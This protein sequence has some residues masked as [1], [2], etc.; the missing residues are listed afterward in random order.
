MACRQNISRRD[1]EIES[2]DWKR[3]RERER[4]RERDRERET[5]T[6]RERDRQTDRQRARETERGRELILASLTRPVQNSR[7]RETSNIC[8][9]FTWHDGVLSALE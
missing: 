6:E 1:R 8:L 5:E 4:E 3:E 2:L 9:I 7:R